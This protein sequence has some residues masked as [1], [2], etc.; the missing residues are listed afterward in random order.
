MEKIEEHKLTF[1][2]V[3]SH[4]EVDNLVDKHLNIFLVHTGAW[5]PVEGEY[6][7]KIEKVEPI[8]PR[9]KAA[10][11]VFAPSVY[12]VCCAI[13]GLTKLYEY[14][15][16]IEIRVDIPYREL[17][18]EEVIRKYFNIFYAGGTDW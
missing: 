16:L 3:K 1:F 10:Y 2:V 14:S 12:D 6:R 4:N 13:T 11:R 8:D 9:A 5:K 18:E 17:N 7:A 15:D